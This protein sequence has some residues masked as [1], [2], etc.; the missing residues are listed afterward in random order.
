MIWPGFP[1][2]CAIWRMRVPRS[3]SYTRSK[4]CLPI[5][6]NAYVAD[7]T[8]PELRG[9]AF[10]LRQSLD[11]VGAFLGPL[12]AVGLMLLWANNFRAVFAVAIIPGLLAVALLM[13]GVRDPDGAER[14]GRQSGSTGSSAAAKPFPP[15]FVSGPTLRKSE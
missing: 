6:A 15:R 8:P 5:K 3:A 10:G 13:F 7:I 9:A 4:A 12:L 2:A 11:T 14:V 1:N